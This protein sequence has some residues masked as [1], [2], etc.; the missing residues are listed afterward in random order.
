MTFNSQSV[1]LLKLSHACYRNNTGMYTSINISPWYG[2]STSMLYSRNKP[3]CQFKI[4]GFNSQSP[5]NHSFPSS[6]YS[7]YKWKAI[8]MHHKKKSSMQF[9]GL[10]LYQETM[11]PLI[12]CM[13]ISTEFYI[14][15]LA[16][17]LAFQT[18]CQH[19]ALLKR[20][21]ILFTYL[22]ELWD[23]FRYFAEIIFKDR[24]ASTAASSTS[25]LFLIRPNRGRRREINKILKYGIYFPNIFSDYM[26]KQAALSGNGKT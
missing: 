17:L 16:T 10:Q 6:L 12:L 3:W 1:L 25:A 23:D 4:S 21:A 7:P 15:L 2:P 18:P 14:W 11:V 9:N 22:L 26:I 5:S 20:V 19:L 24:I 8:Q 13:P